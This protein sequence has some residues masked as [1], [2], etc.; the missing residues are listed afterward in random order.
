MADFRVDMTIEEI[1]KMMNHNQGITEIMYAGPCFLQYKL[2]E[3]LLEAQE[4]QNEELLEKQNTYNK[5]QLLWTRLLVCG[6]WALVI[7]TLLLIKCG[8]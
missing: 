7:V 2:Q 8:S 3:K 6:T 1:L 5:K 4:K